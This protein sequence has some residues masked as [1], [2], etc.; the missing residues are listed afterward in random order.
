MP[1]I[2]KQKKAAVEEKPVCL[3]CR[4]N[5]PVEETIAYSK[6]AKG[7]LCL[8]CQRVII[9]ERIMELK[10]PKMFMKSTLANFDIP[11]K[12]DHREQIQLVATTIR[13][14]ANDFHPDK[15]K[16]LLLYGTVGTGKSHLAWGVLKH[17]AIHK[18][19][20]GTYR[21]FG[22]LMEDIRY[23]FNR[24]DAAQERDL[25]SA[26]CHTKLLVL[27]E[28]GSET[29][30]DY[31]MKIVQNILSERYNRMLPTIVITNKNENE[32]LQIFSERSLDRLLAEGN[33]RIPFAWKSYRTNKWRK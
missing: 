20:V 25:V 10:V 27:D 18:G 28:V 19:I 14:Y 12:N 23:G 17:V 26:L 24:K 5:E 3:R 9:R 30:T 15:S 32:F 29:D 4:E 11:R 21:V 13:E 7:T 8:S 22:K 1:K 31:E 33:L 16:N 2:K 6:Y